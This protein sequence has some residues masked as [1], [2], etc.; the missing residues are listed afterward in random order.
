MPSLH[1]FPQCS[2]HPK[3]WMPSLPLRLRGAVVGG[4]E[5]EATPSR[6]QAGAGQ[7]LI[8]HLAPENFKI[9]SLCTILQSPQ[10][11]APLGKRR[12]RIH[13][14]DVFAWISTSYQGFSHTYHLVIPPQR[15]EV[16]NIDVYL[17]NIYVVLT[18]CWAFF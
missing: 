17:T 6:S 16:S 2:P 15:F 5:W 7:H 13:N 10:T 18:V 3:R 9:P 4:G 11:E 14:C 12:K 1:A 8:T